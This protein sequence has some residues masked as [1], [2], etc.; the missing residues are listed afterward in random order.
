MIRKQ[1]VEM[2]LLSYYK[3]LWNKENEHSSKLE[4]IVLSGDHMESAFLEIR[5]QRECYKEKIAPL[6]SNYNKDEKISVF[7]N[8]IDGVKIRR[9]QLSLFFSDRLN[10]S[11]DEVEAEKMYNRLLHHG[12]AFLNIF[13]MFSAKGLPF[14]TMLLS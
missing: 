6:V 11:L 7:V 14:Y 4:L 2:F 1:L 3:I 12:N 8:H 5:T 9:K 13:G 10:H